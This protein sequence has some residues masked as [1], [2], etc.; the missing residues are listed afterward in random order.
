MSCVCHIH[1]HVPIRGGDSQ[2]AAVIDSTVLLLRCP[3][4]V[5]YTDMYLREEETHKKLLSL[6]VQ[7][8]CCDVLC[9]SHTQ[10]CTYERRRITRSCCHLQ[11]SLTAAMSC[12]CHKHRH[13]PTRGGDS[14]EA[15]VIDSTVLLLRCPLSVT[16]TD[17]YLSEEETHKKLLSLTVQSY[18]CDVLCLSHTQT[19]TYE[20]RRLTRSCCH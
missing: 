9:L 19:C 4:S 14:Q 3:V 17:V 1:R 5:T 10:T 18:C 15:A 8:Y 16:Y 20:R 12:V 7:S 2:E 13:V 6:T 11:Y